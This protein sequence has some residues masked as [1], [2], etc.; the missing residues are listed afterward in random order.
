MPGHSIQNPDIVALHGATMEPA[1]L[2][3]RTFLLLLSLLLGLSEREGEREVGILQRAR[4]GTAFCI[5]IDPHLVVIAER[6]G[7]GAIDAVTFSAVGGLALVDV[8]ADRRPFTVDWL[9]FASPKTIVG[10][11]SRRG[12]YARI[13]IRNRHVI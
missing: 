9:G 11:P 6:S 12:E 5:R 4:F 2:S 13:R 8:Q 1:P 3:K 7:A 10:T